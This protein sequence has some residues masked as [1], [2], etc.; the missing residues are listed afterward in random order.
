MVFPLL[1]NGNL[2]VGVAVQAAV[3]VGIVPADVEAL[4]AAA[5]IALIFGFAAGTRKIIGMEPHEQLS[6]DAAR[7][8]H[9][10]RRKNT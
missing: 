10:G 3:G 1:S 2:R 9:S 7:L 6:I 5:Q 4:G 8:F